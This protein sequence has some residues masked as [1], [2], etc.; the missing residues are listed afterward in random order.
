TRQVWERHWAAQ[1]RS[2]VQRLLDADIAQVPGII[3]EIEA[4]RAW[5]DPLLREEHA[6]ATD[7][8]RQKLHTSLALLPVDAGQTEYL[9]GRLLTAEPNQ[10]IV[11]REA[12]LPHAERLSERLWKVL[13]DVKS[14]P[15]QRLRA[16]C[17]LAGYAEEDDRWP[18]VN[19]DVA[20][21]LVAENAFVIGK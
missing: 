20:A 1:A 18:Q 15:G 10:M 5:A 17:T 9:Y 13:E 16:A 2:L 12:L 7:A 3:S 6:K 8:S 21:R 4:H 14:A 19:N 11:L